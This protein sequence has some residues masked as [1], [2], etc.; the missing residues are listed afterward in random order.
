VGSYGG[1]IFR[2]DATG[3]CERFP[4]ATAALPSPFE[5]CG[6]LPS[7]VEEGVRGWWAPELRAK[8]NHPLGCWSDASA[9]LAS[10]LEQCGVLPSSVEEGV[11]EVVGSAIGSEGQ[12]PLAPIGARI[13]CYFRP[14]VT[15]LRWECS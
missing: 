7:S 10:P 4:D 1:G 11:R 15:H 8:A 12:P 6:C 3:R 2:L 5:Q 14:A 9:A 13:R